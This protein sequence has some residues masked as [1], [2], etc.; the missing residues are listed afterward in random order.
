MAV[1]RIPLHVEMEDGS[2]YDVVIDQ[3]D[4]A[5]WELQSFYDDDRTTLRQ[6][7]VAYA[8]S[9]RGKLTD[10]SWPK[11]NDACVEVIDGRGKAEDVDPTQPDQP[12]ED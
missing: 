6:R 8:A 9:V 10:L 12:A 4:V 3:R 2:E 11:F 1:S 7:Y 5:K